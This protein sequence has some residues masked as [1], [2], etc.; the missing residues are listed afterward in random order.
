MILHTNNFNLKIFSPFLF[1]TLFF[2]INAKAQNNLIAI[3]DNEHI[4][5]NNKDSFKI[6]IGHPA[7]VRQGTTLFK[8]DSIYISDKNGKY[9]EA[10]GNIYINEN[11]SVI[12]TA[13]YLKYFIDAKIANLKNNVTIKSKGGVFTTINEVDYNLNSKLATY[14]K[15]GKIVGKTTTLTS[16]TGQ[17]YAS[18]KDA[19]FTNGVVL[20]GPDYNVNTDTLYYNVNTEIATFTTYTKI[21]N[22]KKGQ[23]IETFGGSYDMRNGI[24]NFTER[25]VIKDKNNTIIADKIQRNDKLK[26]AKLLGKASIIRKDDEG[27]TEIYRGEIID[28]DEINERYHIEQNGLFSSEKE[29]FV[30][31]GNYIDG[32]GKTG[33]FLA[34]GKPVAI[35]KQENDS[36]FIAADTLY[37]G[38]I[39]GGKKIRT[40]SLFKDSTIKIKPLI[41]SKSDTSRFF[42]GF[43]HV[44]IFTDSVQAICDSL[45]Y[46]EVDSV[47]RLYQNPIVWNDKNQITADTM[48]LITKNKKIQRAE[49]FE[50]AFILNTVLENKYYNQIKSNF[51]TAYFT[52]GEMDSLYN[53][54]SAQ[55]IFYIQDDDKAYIGVDKSSADIIIANFANKEITKIKWINKYDGIT[56]PMKDVDSEKSKLRGFNPQQN[57]R[58]KSKFELFF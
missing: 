33:K 32:D 47:F 42:E 15:G 55:I 27:K 36:I 52:D 13:Q 1:L 25:S 7:I 56:T 4:Y 5:V 48:Y 11:D 44:K 19:L 35:I 20:F 46:N 16:T 54:G 2:N 37:S 26:T 57:R 50:N 53:K 41:K 45:Y 21:V 23:T 8:A 22:K 3:G 34:T 14:T 28:I 38:R 39:I 58:P 43:H 29:N 12:T 10:F 51:S 18:T 9:L 31:T 30:I 17:Y 40:D 49:L 24:S 6:V